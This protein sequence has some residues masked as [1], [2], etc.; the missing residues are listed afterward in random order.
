MDKQHIL[1]EIARTADQNG[2][3]PLGRA[4]FLQETGI[5]ET[6]WSGVHWARWSDALAEAGYP[7]NQ[8]NAALDD[9]YLLEQYAAFAHELGRLPVEAELKLKRKASPTFP[10]HNT[11]RRLGSRREFLLKVADY[12]RGRDDLSGVAHLCEVK[13]SELPAESGSASGDDDSDF[14]FVY[15]IQS[16]RYHKIGKSNSVGRRERELAIQ[17]PEKS[18]T[19]H[20]IR[21]DDPAGIEAY[22]HVRFASKRKNGEWFE[23]TTADVKAFRRRK[24]M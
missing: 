15:L 11:F 20:V 4:R 9:D 2:G 7:A 3:V 17:L 12:S 23:L 14:G 5:R 10:S 16:G 19:V 1:A 18:R 24:F 21:T 6:D 8:M 13:A 22:W